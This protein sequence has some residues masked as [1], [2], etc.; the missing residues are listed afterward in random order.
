M[1][2]I[3]EKIEKKDFLTYSEVEKVK[4]NMDIV[5]KHFNYKEVVL[6]DF[7]NWFKIDIDNKILNFIDAKKIKNIGIEILYTK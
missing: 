7:N 4:N 3:I 6:L 5:L 1:K 2:S